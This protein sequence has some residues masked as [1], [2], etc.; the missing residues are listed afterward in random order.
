M[1]LLVHR[2]LAYSLA[3]VLCLRFP[4]VVLSVRGSLQ[5]PVSYAEQLRSVTRSVTDRRLQ[6]DCRCRASLGR[7]RDNLVSE[8]DTGPTKVD[9][10]GQEKRRESRHSK[11][12]DAELQMENVLDG[13]T[14]SEL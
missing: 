9:Y 12:A 14:V 2:D 6:V 13:R 1:C 10:A 11:S 5:V 3:C 7:R 4:V 8:Q